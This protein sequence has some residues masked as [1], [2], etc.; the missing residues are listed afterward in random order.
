MGAES[1][2]LEDYDLDEPS[3]SSKSTWTLRH[4]RYN[5]ELDVTVLSEQKENGQKWSLLQKNIK[6]LKSLRH[7]CIVKY[8]NTANMSGELYLVIE[9]SSP[10]PDLLE[11]L[12]PL[13]ITTGIHSV[14]EGLSFLHEQARMSHNNVCLDSVYVTSNGTWKISDLQHCCKFLEVTP[15][16][17]KNSRPFRNKESISPEEKAERL[18]ITN[19]MGHTRDVF[20]FGV[21]AETL[22]EYILEIGEKSKTFE[23]LVQD[24]CLNADPKQRPK[25]STL[26]KDQLFCND[27]LLI[28]KFLR[29]LTLKP[30]KEKEEFFSSLYPRLTVLAEE[31]VAKQLVQLLLSRFVLLEASAAMSIVPNILVPKRGTSEKVEVHSQ[32][33]SPLFSVP[34]YKTYVI[35]ELIKMFHCHD[36]HIRMILLTYFP[37]YMD[38]F[39]KN[40]LEEVIFPQ[41]LLGV[42]DCHEDLASQSLHCL[43]D[44]V[45]VLGRDT[46][47]G[48][49]SKAYFTQG[50]PK[51]LPRNAIET[52]SGEALDKVLLK[53]LAS[54]STLTTKT[55]NRCNSVDEK[56]QERQNKLKEQRM[57]R[58]QKRLEQ[59]QKR[60][61]RR[62]KENEMPKMNMDSEGSQSQSSRNLLSPQINGHEEIQKSEH[63]LPGNE[64]SERKISY[65]FED[66]GVAS[67]DVKVSKSWNDDRLDPDV[68][69]TSDHSGDDWSDWDN[70]MEDSP[71]ANSATVK[72]VELIKKQDVGYSNH[73]IESSKKD[74]DLYSKSSPKN[75]QSK[76]M[77]SDVTTKKADTR[78]SVSSKSSKNALKLQSTKKKEPQK[79]KKTLGAEFEIKSI[80]TPPVKVSVETDYF[81]DMGLTPVITKGTTSEHSIQKDETTNKSSSAVKASN[82][83]TFTVDENSQL[84]SSGWGEDTGGWGDDDLNWAEED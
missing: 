56:R 42:R 4:G 73:S 5:D 13:E 61:E 9:R 84:D 30:Q 23:I 72:S 49:K 60:K 15:D 76:S 10:L 81:A 20:S 51:H 82:L 19:E 40:D 75:I 79:E 29:E 43:A 39:E 38:L 80:S 65:D 3:A 67:Y 24:K 71:N 50:S 16:F 26:M 25:F 35:P 83:L 53:D 27:L 31:V 11:T 59:Q 74:D 37:L 17:L 57:A 62:E 63:S 32:R 12:D 47:I 7:P 28:T 44:L 14:M 70:S 33:L 55:E 54:Y 6:F 34:L 69:V 64:I 66:Q 68:Y 36:Y 22:L 2:V 48:G 58:E 18:T 52:R 45:K 77:E 1:S 78:N 8:L 41:I 21:M 46:V